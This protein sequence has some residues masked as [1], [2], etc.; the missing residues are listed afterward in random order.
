MRQLTETDGKTLK[1]L[2]QIMCSSLALERGVHGEHNL[3][4]SAFRYPSNEPIDAEVPRT[5]SL[6]RRKAAA[7]HVIA[8]RKQAGAIERPKISDLLDDAEH[9]LIAPRIFADRTG[10]RGVDI[11][12]N[13][14]GRKPLGNVLER[15]E[16]RLESRFASFHEMKDCPAGGAWPQTG[17]TRERLT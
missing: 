14:A 16:Q 3:V 2:D 13:R 12:A 11:A 4:H 6:Q 10:I 17:K 7:E 8:A 1:S 5:Y 15:G 9:F